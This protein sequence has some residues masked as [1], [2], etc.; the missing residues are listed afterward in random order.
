MPPAEWKK[1][2]Q[3]EKNDVLAGRYTDKPK[4]STTSVTHNPEPEVED[5]AVEVPACNAG[6]QFDSK[7]HKK[8]KKR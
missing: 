6:T 7:A 4:N 3:E 2:S 5:D 8:H 1:L